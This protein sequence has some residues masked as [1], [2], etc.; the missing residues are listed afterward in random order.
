MPT[1]LQVLI[2]IGIAAVIVGI[3]GVVSMPS[4]VKLEQVDFPVWT[5][6]L[7]EKFLNVQVADTEPR[8]MRGLMFQ[9]TLPYDQGMLF[10]FDGPGERSMW[11]LNM[12]FHLDMIWFDENGNVI[13]ITKNVPPCKTPLEVMACDTERISADNVKYILEVTSGFVEKFSI[14]NESKLYIDLG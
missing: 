9:E 14:D 6:K 11:M 8:Q 1:R 2:P 12:Q 3:A 4:E 7:D 10:V 5:I 13:Q